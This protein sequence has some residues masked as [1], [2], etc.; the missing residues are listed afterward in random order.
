MKRFGIKSPQSYANGI[1]NPKSPD[2]IKASPV[3]RSSPS[4]KAML[5]PKVLSPKQ[6]M[7]A[8]HQSIDM[9]QKQQILKK[10]KLSNV[11][12]EVLDH[13]ELKSYLG[14]GSF[15]TVMKAEC[16]VSGQ[17]VAIK[18]LTD[19]SKYDYDCCKVI[20]EIQVMTNL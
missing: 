14:K 5:S 17:I 12:L 9:S 2:R 1:Q 15:G 11:W 8:A 10:L 16:K 4:R 13:Y 7:K 6:S 18:H 20:R 3:T 19:F